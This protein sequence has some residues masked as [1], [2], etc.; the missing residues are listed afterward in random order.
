MKVDLP[1]SSQ[2]S[3]N[4]TIADTNKDVETLNHHAVELIN[5]SQVFATKKGPFT[6]LQDVNFHV[7]R[8]EFVSVVGPSGCGKST[9][10]GLI[11]GLTRPHS[12]TVRVLGSEV[13]RVDSRVGVIF[14]RDALLPWR[15]A[16]E[17]VELALRYRGRRRNEAQRVAR[18][19]L[20]RVGLKGFESSYPHQLSGGMRKRVSI[21]ATMCYE[22]DL[23]LM[24][25]PFSALDVQTRSLMENDLL[26]IWS[27][28]DQSVIFI[29]H[30]L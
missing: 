1:N 23:L 13:T 25:E 27:Q 12:G 7:E 17:N 28:S 15:T 21:A 10:V 16:L 6:A 9:L 30:D 4:R 8:G 3:L 29:T 22:P 18:D 5:V 24:D 26:D 14:Q 2:A 19:W 20:A 11:S